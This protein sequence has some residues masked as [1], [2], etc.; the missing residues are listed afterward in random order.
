L[1][2]STSGNASVR[3]G[4]DRMVVTA[5]RSELGNLTPDD[6]TV[7]ALDD[8]TILEG[9]EPS[10]E[11][12]LHRGVYRVR[13]GARSVLHCQSRYATL[14]ACLENPPTDLD[15][16]PEVPAYVRAHAYVPYAT[17]G[18]QELAESVARALEDPEVTVAQLCNHG[19]VIVG[20]N[21][22]K[23][24]RRGVFFELACWMAT[25]GMPLRTISPAEVDLLRDYARDV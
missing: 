24:V 4:D 14:I 22:Q 23:T 11:S 15:F 19:Q 10:L 6:V 3:L 16:I 1:L 17:P 25:R 18:S 7:L 20:A 21:W 2:T 5:A 8:G 13:P 12:D 9:P